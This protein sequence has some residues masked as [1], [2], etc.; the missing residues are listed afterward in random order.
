[1]KTISTLILSMLLSVACL[2]QKSD[3]FNQISSGSIGALLIEKAYPNPV[4][5]FV[6]IEIQTNE[7]GELQMSLYNILGTEVKKWETYYLNSGLQKV[8]LDL[9]QFKTGVYILRLTKQGQTKAQ[10]LKKV[11]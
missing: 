5:D 11:E 1:M 6:N 3:S 7:P 8:Q 4:K 9:S 2:A 10:I